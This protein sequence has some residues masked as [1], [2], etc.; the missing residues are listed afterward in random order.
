MTEEVPYKTDPMASRGRLYLEPESQTR[1]M[2][3]RD[4]DRLIHSSAFRRLKYKT[5]VFDYNCPNFSKIFYNIL[6]SYIDYV[7][8]YT[9]KINHK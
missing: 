9:W 3:Q 6:L 8:E 1:T 4:R 5:Q 2:F 7:N